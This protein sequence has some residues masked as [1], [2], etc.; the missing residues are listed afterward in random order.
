MFNDLPPELTSVLVTALVGVVVAAGAAV[1]RLLE[2]LGAPKKAA[3]LES[4]FGSLY[5][6]ARQSVIAAEELAHGDSTIGSEQKYSFAVTAVKDWA[7][8]V[9]LTLSDVE[10]A[11]LINAAVQEFRSITTAVESN[12]ALGD[13]Q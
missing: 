8:K 4:K 11:S 10:A 7:G 5:A 13:V 12:R 2:R 6:F 3:A 9:G 1:V